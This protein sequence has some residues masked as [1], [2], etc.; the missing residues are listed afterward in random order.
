MT[1]PVSKHSMYHI[2]QT[3]SCLTMPF[4]SSPT[5]MLNSALTCWRLSAPPSALATI[6]KTG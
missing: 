2:A 6:R 4:N 1:K 5:Q 3:L